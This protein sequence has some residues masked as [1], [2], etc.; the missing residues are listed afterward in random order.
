MVSRRYFSAFQTFDSV[1]EVTSD[2]YSCLPSRH[3]SVSHLTCLAGDQAKGGGQGLQL[4]FP[5]SI[6]PEEVRWFCNVF[7]KYR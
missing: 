6:C 5:T 1:V 2:T 4:L 3:M 7:N